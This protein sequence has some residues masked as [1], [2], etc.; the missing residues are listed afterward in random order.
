MIRSTR[1]ATNPILGCGLQLL[2]EDNLIQIHEAALEVLAYTGIG[3]GSAKA[4]KIF[5]DNGAKVDEENEIVYIP[6]YM[7]EEAVRLAP[8]NVLLGGRNPKNNVMVGG[9]RVS[10][11]AFGTA[12]Y[13]LDPHTKKRRL[14]TTK[15]V[16]NLGL[17]TDA[18]DEMDICF[19][20]A[21]PADITNDDS[22]I[23]HAWEAHSNNT[24]KNIVSEAL[25]GIG[26]DV[27][28]EMARLVVGGQKELEDRPVITLGGCPISPLMIPGG[29]GDALISGAKSKVPFLLVS[30]SLSGGTAPFTVGGTLVVMTAEN[31]ACTVLAQLVRK[32]APVIF[33]SSTTNMDPRKGAATVGSPELAL[34]SAAFGQIANFYGIPSMV[35][36]G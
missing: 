29:F 8:K 17:L 28:I 12:V 20:T 10:F 33:G 21:L 26:T 31:L 15:D 1:S 30:C 3:C 32:G 25:D 16:E 14:A 36:G 13:V 18:L 23:W 11:N 9:K 19:E 4:R 22:A 5:S 2:N 35:A 24:T 6:S 7:V 27:L 34:I